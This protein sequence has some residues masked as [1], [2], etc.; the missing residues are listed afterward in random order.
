MSMFSRAAGI[1]NA[2]INDL[3]DKAADP[4]RLTRQMIREADEAIVAGRAALQRQVAD[5]TRA[6]RRLDRKQADVDR[7]RKHAERAVAEGRDD[8]A[9]QA[10][11]RKHGLGQEAKELET[12]WWECET[13]REEAEALLQQLEDRVQELRRRRESFIARRQRDQ[14]S[15]A[16]VAVPPLEKNVTEQA[17]RD[18]AVESELDELKK[19]KQDGGD[20][21]LDSE[22]NRP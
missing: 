4:V 8:Q 16:F 18:L 20:G 12:K 5:A 10:L 22:P 6:R 13:K 15:S 2:N 11:E 21:D 14:S 9:R 7:W 3:L 17:C 1:L 19:R